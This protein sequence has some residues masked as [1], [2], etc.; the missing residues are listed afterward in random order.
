LRHRNDEIKARLLE[1]NQTAQGRQ[2]DDEERDEWNRLSTEHDQNEEAVREG[3]QREAW[4]SELATR[5][6]NREKGANFGVPAARSQASREDLW[7]LTTIRSAFA[8]PEAQL[9]EA[10]DRC[11]RAIEDMR[12]PHPDVQ[13]GVVSRSVIQNHMM[14]LLETADTSRGDLAM[15]MLRTGSP[16]YKRAFSKTAMGASLTSDE[17]RALA[18]S[19]GSTGGYAIPIT[20]DPTM[21]P[22]SNGVVNPI[23]S[24]ARVETIVGLEYRGLTAGAVVASYAQEG[25]EVADNS[26]TIAQPDVFVERAQTF[27]P[28]S[29]EIGMDWTGLQA[30]LARLITDAK[31]VLEGNKFTLGAG[32]ASFEP[33][34]LITGATTTTGSAGSAS[35]AI[36]DLY[37]LEESL[38]PRYRPMGVFLGNRHVYNLIRQFGQNANQNLWMTIQD[39]AGGPLSQGLANRPFGEGGSLGQRLLGYPTYEVSDMVTTLTTG[40]KVLILGDPNYYL[41]V[42]RI[43]M[44]VEFVPHLFGSNRRPTGQRGLYAY[45]RNTGTVVDPS[46]WRVLITT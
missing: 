5:D 1:M 14:T 16:L 35:F 25:T 44:Q 28:Y 23:R 12:F 37:A 39:P 20:L 2:F 45:W 34:G 13:N 38:P 24:I 4:L 6:N 31:D 46:A 19:T 36:G 33:S 15:Y 41:I 21:I 26:P 7:D 40:S 18:E 10:R 9:L 8:S 11:K 42:D 17:S 43:G 29:I 32:H 22:I 3:E 30:N 27:V